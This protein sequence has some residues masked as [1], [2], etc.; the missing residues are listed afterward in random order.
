[1]SRQVKRR[2]IQMPKQIIIRYSGNDPSQAPVRFFGEKDSSNFQILVVG[3]ET[4]IIFT[5]SNF[6]IEKY[7]ELKG[8]E[9]EKRLL[10]R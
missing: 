3:E 4:N 5:G 1:M 6:S 10:S 9:Q 2:I 7:R 8:E